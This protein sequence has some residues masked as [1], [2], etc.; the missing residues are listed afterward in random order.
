M[1]NQTRGAAWALCGERLVRHITMRRLSTALLGLASIVAFQRSLHAQGARPRRPGDGVLILEPMSVIAAKPSRSPDH[2]RLQAERLASRD[3]LLRELDLARGRWAR[4]SPRRV[5]YR[6]RQI[7]YCV[8]SVGVSRDFIVEATGD[9]VVAATNGGILTLVPSPGQ[10]APSIGYLFELAE[11]AI[12]G[13]ADQIIVT[14]DAL[15]GIPTRVFVDPRAGT[16][17]DEDDVLVSDI[18]V[19]RG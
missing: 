9:S 5:R 3:S 2:E 18:A 16:T 1:P 12:R 19:I 8:A 13:N 15:L 4:Q 17:D 6:L 7:C 10:H 11:R 14:F